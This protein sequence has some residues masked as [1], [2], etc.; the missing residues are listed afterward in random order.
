M[1][2]NTKGGMA[3][4]IKLDEDK[5]KNAGYD[6]ESVIKH[7]DKFFSKACKKSVSPSGEII[8]EGIEGKDHFTEIM[9]T[10]IRL[11]KAEWFAESCIK[12]LLY[13][14]DKNDIYE[15]DLL[16]KERQTN[17]LFIKYT[18]K[19]KKCTDFEIIEYQAAYEEQVKD[20]LVELQTYLSFLDKRGVLVLK[21]SYRNDYFQY[22]MREVENNSGKI[23]IAVS[24]DRAVGA[25]VCKIF[26]GGGEAEI[27]TSCP[28]IGFISDLVV[29]ENQ[30]GNGIGT[31]LLSAAET[32]F[33][34][35]NCRY[36]Q[37]E[38]FAPNIQARRLYEKFGFGVN[39]YY[40][41]KEIK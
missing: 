1:N 27:T 39:C 6:V 32:Y 20:L 3:M 31:N 41:S 38:V 30:R 11:R 37:L 19:I 23:F 9:L 33:K 35:N 21:E 13:E 12:W 8:Y 25:V 16:A 28:K 29:S 2:G 22:V 34:E 5:L 10:Y 18:P 40:M 14:S 7:L 26:Q 4:L 15:E 36:I 17:P 24:G